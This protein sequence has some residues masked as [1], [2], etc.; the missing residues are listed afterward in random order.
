M[1]K[2]KKVQLNMTMT[3]VLIQMSESNPG[4]ISVMVQLLKKDENNFMFILSLDDMNIRGEQIWVGY[5]DYCK[6]NID[7]FIEAIKTRDKKM[8]DV[9]NKECKRYIAVTSGGSWEHKE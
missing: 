5:K 2:R 1:N 6:E 8:V 4:A 3:D 9:I 7:T